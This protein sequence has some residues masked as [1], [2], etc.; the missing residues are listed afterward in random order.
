MVKRLLKLLLLHLHQLLKLL[1]LLLLHPHPLLLL[2]PHLLLLLPL[3]L[4]PWLLPLTQ[5]RSKLVANQQKS[6]RK[7]AFLFAQ[8]S[9]KT[10]PLLALNIKRFRASLSRLA[11]LPR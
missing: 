5:P 6:R 8:D 1:L 10:S 2:M 4:I 3:L 11:G 9:A 7:S